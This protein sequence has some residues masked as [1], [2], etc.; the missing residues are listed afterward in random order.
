MFGRIAGRYDLLNRLLSAGVDR[1]WRRILLRQAG[2]LEGRVF[3]DSCCG[4]GD[5]ALAFGRAGARTIGV[6][7]TAEM[8]AQARAKRSAGHV[9]V[10]AGDAL[11]LPIGDGVADVSAIAFGIRNVADRR[12]GLAE[13]ARVVRPGG[14]VLVLEFSMPRGRILGALYRVY[15]TRILPRLGGW[16]S[17]DPGAYR[18]LAETVVAWPSP[19]E[20]RREMEAVGLVRCGERRLTG[21]IACLS[22][23]SVPGPD[24]PGSAR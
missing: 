5:L 4:T 10:V 21:G 20:F 11:R 19:E 24:G 23:G 12:R 22:W 17:G 18:Y 1:R 3:V 6:D 16:I 14:R 9:L 15:F 7:F 13:L 8:L 2:D